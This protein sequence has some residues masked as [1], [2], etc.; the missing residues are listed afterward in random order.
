[1]KEKARHPLELGECRAHLR[2]ATGSSTPPGTAWTP[3]NTP[4]A[5][6]YNRRVGSENAP[7]S[8]LRAHS[9]CARGCPAYTLTLSNGSP[10]P[11]HVSAAGGSRHKSRMGHFGDPDRT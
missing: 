7:A 3:W 6:A 9:S 5:T 2:D 11:D 4:G 10:F 1:M 8:L